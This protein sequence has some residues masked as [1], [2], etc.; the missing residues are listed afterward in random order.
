MVSRP[1]RDG[2]GSRLC[3][4]KVLAPLRIRRTRQDPRSERWKKGCSNTAQKNAHTHWNKTQMER[5]GNELARISHPMPTYLIWNENQSY[6]SSAHARQTKP[7]QETDCQSLDLRQTPHK[8]ANME[9]ECQ[10]LDL[11]QTPNQQTHTGNQLPI[12]GLT[13]DSTQTN[14]NRIRNAN[15]WSYI[16][17]QTHRQ[18]WKPNANR[19]TYIRL[20]T[21]EHTGNRLPIAGL[22]SDSKQANTN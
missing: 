14:T 17:L 22:M 20:R 5:E 7:T 15:R 3:E 19:W 9:T 2:I 18:T 1:K 21:N 6:R 11:H 16:Q 13:S 4:G 10:S 12:A 8:Q